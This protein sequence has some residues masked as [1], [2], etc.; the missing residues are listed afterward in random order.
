V[1]LAPITIT[2]YQNVEFEPDDVAFLTA[3]V[4]GRLLSRDI[5]FDPAVDAVSTATM[6]SALVFDTLR[7][8][9]ETWADMVKT[10]IARP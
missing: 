3:R 7:R 6:S 5:V 10:G 1:N 9:R 2:K 4:V 8:L